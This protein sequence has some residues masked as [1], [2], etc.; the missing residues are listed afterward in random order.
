M[1]A[2]GGGGFSNGL[3]WASV[4]DSA[5]NMRALSAIQADG[6]RAASELVD[7]FVR[8]ASAGA[9]APGQPAAS[10]PSAT[11]DQ[12]DLFGATGLEPFVASWWSMVD[13]LLRVTTPDSG[14]RSTASSPT[15]DLS[16]GQADGR[17]FLELVPAGSATS[18]V[19]LHNGGPVDMGKI[20]LRCSDFLAHDGTVIAAGSVGFQPDEVPI[21]ERSSRGVTVAVEL[22]ED[23]APGTYRGMIVVDGRPDAWLPVELV[24]KPLLP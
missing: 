2:A 7:R 11:Q 17:L 4:F 14:Q 21:P 23:A 9:A 13:Q 3:P 24:V 8:M 5:S 19:W 22:A 20:R 12:A 15:L 1:E 10:T 18:E 6:F 16:K